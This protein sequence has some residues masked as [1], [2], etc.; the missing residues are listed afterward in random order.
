V[1]EE[2]GRWH[3]VYLKKP[4]DDPSAPVRTTNSRKDFKSLVNF[5]D[6]E[7]VT[8]THWRKMTPGKSNTNHSSA[9]LHSVASCYYFETR[10][11]TH[12]MGVQT[13]FLGIF[14]AA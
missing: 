10:Q 14:E 11:H 12:P 3:T 5:Q 13:G 6:D 1:S 2:E 8:D 7:Q 4:R 9:L